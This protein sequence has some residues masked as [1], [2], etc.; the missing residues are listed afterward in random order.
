MWWWIN[1]SYTKESVTLPCLIGNR[2][3]TP[4][5]RTRTSYFAS[6]Q[7]EIFKMKKFHMGWET[8][9]LVMKVLIR[10]LNG[11]MTIS[12]LSSKDSSCF[13]PAN[14]P[15]PNLIFQSTTH[16]CAGQDTLESRKEVPCPPCSQPH[17]RYTPGV[18]AQQ[19]DLKGKQDNQPKSRVYAYS[20][21]LFL[22]AVT[23]E[24]TKHRHCSYD[25]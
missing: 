19:W 24:N 2:N 21:G 18:T 6:A 10:L 16:L 9:L 14:D 7:E 23:T 20:W 11:P 15:V 22:T 13:Q 17:Q 1:S 25:F 3:P 5:T 8:Q 12:S 4:H